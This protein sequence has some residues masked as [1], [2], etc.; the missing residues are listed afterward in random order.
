MEIVRI[1]EKNYDI[2]LFLDTNNYYGYK[3]NKD[4]TIEKIDRNVFKY[5]NFLTCSSNF[6]VL[7]NIGDY[8]VVL[9][10]N[11]NFKHF[12]KNDSE[13]YEMFFLNNGKEI[14]SYQSIDINRAIRN[15]SKAF[16]IGSTTVC[17]SLGAINLVNANE[18]KLTTNAQ[19]IVVVHQEETSQQKVNED[20]E[21]KLIAKVASSDITYED[22]VNL[23]NSSNN[24]SKE[25]KEFLINKRLIEDVL[26]MVNTTNITKYDVLTS[27]KDL[28]IEQYSSD[29]DNVYG[30]YKS[31]TPNKIY[32]KNYNG[33]NSYIKDTI[34]HEYIHLYQ[35]HYCEYE[36]LKEA[37]AEI[38]SDEYFEESRINAYS[39]QVIIVKKLMEIIGPEPVWQYTFTG[40]FSMIEKNIKPYLSEDQYKL[41]TSCLSY[42]YDDDSLNEKKFD[43]L[44]ILLGIIY[45]NKYNKNIKE[46]EIISLYDNPNV[47]VRRYYFN[48]DYINQDNSYYEDGNNITTTSMTPT[49]AVVNEYVYVEEEIKEYITNDQIQNYL[50]THDN[51]GLIRHCS[52]IKNFKEESAKFKDGSII[53]SGYLDD[54]YIKEVSEDELVKKGIIIKCEYYYVKDKRYLSTEEYLSEKYDKNNQLNYIINKDKCYNLVFNNEGDFE[55]YQS[56]IVSIPT[57]NEKFGNDR[58]R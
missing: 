9:D 35:Y 40:D 8:K 45:N 51:K 26:K 57:I 47:Q 41:F 12:F 5:F 29:E 49:A 19:P 24:L 42:N 27:L 20:D 54:K 56:S 53:I 44:D 43:N 11:T 7:P 10:N 30:Y 16:I 36:V 25:E 38:I 6:S 2:V 17:L 48:N 31:T 14:I 55:I 32:V 28:G 46:D 15:I 3:F 33:I 39:R 37:T 4:N 52:Y 50:K 34:S 23:I 22:V 21:D 18:S 58:V 13:D 1:H